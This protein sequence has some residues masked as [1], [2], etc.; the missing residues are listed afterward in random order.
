MAPNGYGMLRKRF[1]LPDYSAIDNVFEF[2]DLKE[3]YLL[4]KMRRHIVDR[5]KEYLEVLEDLIHP[6]SSV[7]AYH[8]YKILDETSKKALYEIYSKLMSHLRVSQRL[9][10]QL[11]DKQ[12]AQFICQINSS[13]PEISAG[14]AQLFSKLGNAWTEEEISDMSLANYLG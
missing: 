4:R 9:D 10:F 13:W 3:P 11:S 1:G 14:L 2:H 8:E 7:S 6:N 12:D 5:I